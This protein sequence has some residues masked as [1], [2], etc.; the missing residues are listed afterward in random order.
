M[1]LCA[2]PGFSQKNKAGTYRIY[3]RRAVTR[4]NE[5]FLHVKGVVDEE[6]SKE[7]GKDYLVVDFP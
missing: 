5:D 4:G 2:E 1:E 7:W 3:P 6:S